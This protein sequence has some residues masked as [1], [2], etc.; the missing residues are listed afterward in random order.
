MSSASGLIGGALVAL[1]ILSAIAAAVRASLWNASRTRLGEL[2][3]RG[4]HG[5]GSALR[6]LA[7]EDRTMG[8]L[9][10]AKLLAAGVAG[11]LAT[12][13]LF[14]HLPPLQAGLVALALIAVFALFGLVLPDAYAARRADRVALMFSGPAR[15]LVAG[16]RAAL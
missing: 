2:Q 5:A 11:G 13:L 4:I 14:H 15:A 16:F 10:L 7:D 9:A 6:L 12:F 1:L 8:A 3:K